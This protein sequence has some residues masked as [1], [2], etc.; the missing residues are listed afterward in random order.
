MCSQSS[1]FAWFPNILS[2]LWHWMDY[3]ADILESFWFNQNLIIGCFV[4]VVNVILQK[5]CSFKLGLTHNSVL[6][7]EQNLFVVKNICATFENLIKL[8][9]YIFICFIWAIEFESNNLPVTTWRRART[10]KRKKTILLLRVNLEY[11]TQLYV[12]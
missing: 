3:C 10:I 12:S 9:I 7:F 5:V 1:F 11:F 6:F 8:L 2:Q 4:S